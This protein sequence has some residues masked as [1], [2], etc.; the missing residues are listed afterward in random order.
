M[1]RHF[2][3]LCHAAT[4]R[5]VASDTSAQGIC[6]VPLGWTGETMSKGHPYYWLPVQSLADECSGYA[7]DL[8]CGRLQILGDQWPLFLYEEFLYNPE[9]P[10]R[11]LFRSQLIISVSYKMVICTRVSQIGDSGL[12]AHF[13]L[14]EF[15]REGT[16]GNPIRQCLYPQYGPRD[17]S[18]HS[19]CCHTGG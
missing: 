12:Q 16:K 9:D 3:P 1:E 13:H 10:W 14:P 7:R 6:S 8:G 18:V 2:S 5:S 15:G 19:L 4:S 17:I 11:G